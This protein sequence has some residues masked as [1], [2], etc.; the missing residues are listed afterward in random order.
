MTW[1]EVFLAVIMVLT[2][3]VGAGVG[4]LGLWLLSRWVRDADREI[5]V[6][7]EILDYVPRVADD[8]S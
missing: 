3:C 1:S 5:D 7:L 2:M 4:L 8:V 6:G